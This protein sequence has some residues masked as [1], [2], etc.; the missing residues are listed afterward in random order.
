MNTANTETNAPAVAQLQKKLKISGFFNI[1][2]IALVAFLAIVLLAGGNQ[3]GPMAAQDGGPNGDTAAVEPG[4]NDALGAEEGG[5]EV[6]AQQVSHVRNDPNDTMAIGDINAPVVI[7]EWTDLRCP[8]CAVF[9]N[10]TMPQII[11]DYVDQGLVRVEFN[12]VAFFGDESLNAAV[13]ARAAGEQG[14]YLPYLEEL[15]ARAPESGHPE[16]PTETLVDIAKAAGVPD[17]DKFN[18]DL[19]SPDLIAAVQESQRN[20]Q[21]WGISAVPFFV[22]G[23]DNQAVSGAQ[24]YEVF[25]QIINEEVAK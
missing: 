6:E 2:L 15:Y 9:A 7:S 3:N 17:M 23:P 22:I 10:Q 1:V 8:F 20:A 21:S 25:Q 18:A 13:A 5:S 14:L 11:Q 4:E 12:D 19:T 24:P 16:L